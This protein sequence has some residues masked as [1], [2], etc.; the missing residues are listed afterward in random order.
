[1]VWFVNII[2]NHKW[3]AKGFIYVM[4]L[5]ECNYWYTTDSFAALWVCLYGFKMV[6]SGGGFASHHTDQYCFL[7]C[8]WILDPLNMLLL[9]HKKCWC[10]NILISDLIACGNQSGFNFMWQ[11]VIMFPMLFLNPKSPYMLSL[12]IKNFWCKNI[13]ISDLTGHGQC[14][15][16]WIQFYMTTVRTQEEQ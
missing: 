7:C 14:E 11:I 10:K 5:C 9:A 3:N 12:H 1:M 4:R 2:W 6:I 15:S 16:V 13:L 8:F